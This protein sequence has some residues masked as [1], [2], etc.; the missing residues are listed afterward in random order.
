MAWT[1]PTTWTTGQ[2]PTAALMNLHIRDN[3]N[4]AGDHTAWAAYTPALTATVT[5]PNPSAKAGHYLRVGNLVVCAYLFTC[6]TTV[7]SGDYMVSLPVTGNMNNNLRCGSGYLYDASAYDSWV[8]VHY[9]SST[10]ATTVKVMWNAKTA[11]GVVTH[12]SPAAWGAN[13]VISGM[14]FYRA[15]T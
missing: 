9:S 5:N 8:T 13:D 14:L 2:T 3:L 1:A 6:G 4:A 10:A 12:A 7:G 11:N 15:A